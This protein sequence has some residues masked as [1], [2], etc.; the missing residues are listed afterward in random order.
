MKTTLAALLLWTVAS[1]A[2]AL[3]AGDK[4]PDFELADYE[5]KKH[6]LSEHKGK[7]VVLEWTSPACPFTLEH[8]ERRT[9]IKTREKHKDKVVWLAIDSSHDVSE[10]ALYNWSK[11]WKID[12]PILM[13]GSGATGRKY[14]ATATPHMFVIDKEGVVRYHGAIDD[15]PTNSKKK[16]VNLVDEAVTALLADKPVKV[17]STAAY[18]CGIKYLQLPFLK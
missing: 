9:M 5:G 11:R 2:P 4:A 16:I 18:G 3:T 8:Y 12:W 10:G 13:D 14:G 17:P 1:T 7:I 6:K 15:D